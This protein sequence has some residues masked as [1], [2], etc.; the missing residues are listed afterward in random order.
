M[1]FI[2]VHQGKP[3]DIYDDSCNG[4]WLL[5]KDIH[6][7]MVWD[8]GNENKLEG[9]DIQTWLEGTYYN[10]FDANIKAAIKQVKIP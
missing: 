10:L 8:A 1:E 5:R 6:S 2:I 3:S 7:Q 4:T 9:S